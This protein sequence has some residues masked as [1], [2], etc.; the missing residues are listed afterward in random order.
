MRGEQMGT[1][2]PIAQLYDK[3]FVNKLPDGA[4][5]NMP[6]SDLLKKA[7]IANALPE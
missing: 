7:M 1:L 2:G 6:M 3:W 4:S 5:L